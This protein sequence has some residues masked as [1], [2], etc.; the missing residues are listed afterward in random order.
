MKRSVWIPTFAIP[1]ASGASRAPWAIPK[2]SDRAASAVGTAQRGRMSAARK[3]ARRLTRG[4][5]SSPLR[6]HIRTPRLPL[7]IIMRAVWVLGS[8]DDRE[9]LGGRRRIGILRLVDGLDL[10]GVAAEGERG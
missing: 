10:E 9:A 5:C 4:P 6:M 8:E 7:P 2:N 3:T 1:W